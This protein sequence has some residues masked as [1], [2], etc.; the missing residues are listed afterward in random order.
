MVSPGNGQESPLQKGRRLARLSYHW[1]PS[2]SHRCGRPS[3]I[4]CLT[5]NGRASATRVRALFAADALK[6]RASN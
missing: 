2:G 3:N 5:G 4:T 6:S 1:V